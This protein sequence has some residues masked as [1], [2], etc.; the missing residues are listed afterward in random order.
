MF[1]KHYTFATKNYIADFVES[2]LD[3]QTILNPVVDAVV[4]RLLLFHSLL[5]EEINSISVNGP[6]FRFESSN[7]DKDSIEAFLRVDNLPDVKIK[8]HIIDVSDFVK[9]HYIHIN[10]FYKDVYDVLK[11]TVGD[12]LVR[13]YHEQIM[14]YVAGSV[15]VKYE[16]FK[17]VRMAGFFYR[18]ATLVYEVETAI[19]KIVEANDIVFRTYD[20]IKG[21]FGEPTSI[22][23]LEV[24]LRL[25]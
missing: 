9:D 5:I 25:L 14:Q 22:T 10:H 24:N 3:K 21:I 12:D 23:K 20:E 15:G 18:R 13:I 2:D 7:K 11:S 8:N 17:P 4:R 1:I 16:N 6:N 19:M